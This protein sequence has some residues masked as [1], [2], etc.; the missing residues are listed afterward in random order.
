MKNDWAAS[1]RLISEASSLLERHEQQLPS[2][3]LSI[4][5][6][7]DPS[8]KGNISEKGVKSNAAKMLFKKCV[9]IIPLDIENVSTIL[10]GML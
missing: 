10:H 2:S 5:V 1:D 3:K 7:S 4:S 6:S 8:E 9:V